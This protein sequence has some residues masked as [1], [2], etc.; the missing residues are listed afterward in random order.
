MTEFVT[1][2]DFEDSPVSVGEEAVKRANLYVERVL[3]KLGVSASLFPHLKDNPHLKE[4]ARVYAY[5][6]SV[7]DYYA[8]DGSESEY[9]EK[10]K[11]YKE[12]LTKTENSITLESLG[13]T[14]SS[15]S[16]GFATFPIRRG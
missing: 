12:L 8:G 14:Q 2:T 11:S 6:I 15:P 4:L 10:V 1:L 13:L 16:V 7:V 9:N 5:Y 3:S